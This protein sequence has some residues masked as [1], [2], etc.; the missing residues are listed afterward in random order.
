MNSGNTNLDARHENVATHLDDTHLN[1]THLEGTHLDGAPAAPHSLLRHASRFPLPLLHANLI[2]PEGIIKTRNVQAQ[3]MNG[4]MKMDTMNINAVLG[5][6]RC[7]PWNCPSTVGS[8]I[9]QQG[10]KLFALRPR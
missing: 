8:A 9:L 1:D 4:N 3:K 5:G 10:S 2:A 6:R 7:N